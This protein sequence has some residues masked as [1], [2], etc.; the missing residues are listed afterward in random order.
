MGK[1]PDKIRKY[2]ERFVA[3]N[4]D[5][6]NTFLDRMKFLEDPGIYY[7]DK[8]II[9]FVDEKDYEGALELID[10]GLSLANNLTMYKLYKLR[11]QCSFELG[12]DLV[13]WERDFE[14]AE[15]IARK[16]PNRS[17]LLTELWWE[18]C[19][20]YMKI[21]DYHEADG[22]LFL[23]N[24][25]SEKIAKNSGFKYQI[26]KRMVKLYDV[27]GNVFYDEI[28]EQA[29]EFRAKWKRESKEDLF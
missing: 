11:G 5:H 16:H 26:F 17:E 22:C 24:L 21:E 19:D 20:L 14:Y 9:R 25:E 23:A 15:R 18:W 6:F 12:K 4:P 28:I 27:T 7:L 10:K 8:A 2:T 3:E 1:I 13:I 29:E